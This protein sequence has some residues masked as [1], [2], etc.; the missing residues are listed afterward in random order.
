MEEGY[1]QVYYGNGQGKSSAAIGQAIRVANG[2]GSVC[3]IRFLKE[4]VSADFVSRLEPEIKIF[5]FEHTLGAFDDLTEEERKEERQNILNGISFARKVLVTGECDL[6]I[7]DEVLG[8]VNIGI[9]EEE[10]LL[11]ALAMR[12]GSTAVILT[13]RELPP[14]VAEIADSIINIVQER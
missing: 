4:P 12:S 8:A 6:L 13:G 3:L 7:L 10:E 9:L 11:S 5:R 2:G 1:I 14:H